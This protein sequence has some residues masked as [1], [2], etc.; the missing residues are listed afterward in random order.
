MT[1]EE[2]EIM[3]FILGERSQNFVFPTISAVYKKRV[4]QSV[5]IID[6]KEVNVMKSFFKMKNTMKIA[7]KI[8]ADYYPETLNKLIIT[9]SGS[10]S[11]L[12]KSK[13]SS[14]SPFGNLLKHGWTKQLNRK[15]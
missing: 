12:T 15:L 11:S 13:G 4:H 1:D 8:S 3:F 5:V 6:L 10:C 14:S 9:H 2:K 7:N